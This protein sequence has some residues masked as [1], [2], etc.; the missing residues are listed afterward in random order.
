MTSTFPSIDFR[1][2]V[3][4]PAILPSA[5]RTGSNSL[6]A[7]NSKGNLS[8]VAAFKARRES[9]RDHNLL[10]RSLLPGLATR[11]PPI[12]RVE[13]ERKCI[14]GIFRQFVQW[15]LG[16][17][18]GPVD[19][20]KKAH[21]DAEPGFSIAFHQTFRLRIPEIDTFLRLGYNLSD[22]SLQNSTAGDFSRTTSDRGTA[23]TP[24]K[25][26]QVGDFFHASFT[27]MSAPD[28]RTPPIFVR[29]LPPSWECPVA[30]CIGTS[31]QRRPGAGRARRVFG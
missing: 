13:T 8:G 31:V 23:C 26:R 21:F 9:G 5:P 3:I 22:R 4:S 25:R 27:F 14:S 15:N 17:T 1:S 10:L 19:A 18:D 20:L 28:L 11:C 30:P 6:L 24:R 2:L 29:Q 16:F 7:G 12:R